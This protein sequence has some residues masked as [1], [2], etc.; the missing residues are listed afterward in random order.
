M[1]QR[2]TGGAGRCHLGRFTLPQICG[3]GARGSVTFEPVPLSASAERDPDPL[4]VEAQGSFW[5]DGH[6]G[7]Q[8]LACGERF[9][10]KSGQ[11]GNCP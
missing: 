10:W 1:K 5:L 3:C 6:G 11:A 2:A 8:C 4:V 9:G 7:I